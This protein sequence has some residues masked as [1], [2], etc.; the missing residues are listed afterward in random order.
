MNRH[1]SGRNFGSGVQAGLSYQVFG[2]GY[3]GLGKNQY[4]G[5]VNNYLAC[6]MEFS[7]GGGVIHRFIQKR[8]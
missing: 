5:N 8:R 3:W 6:T 1:E 7:F 2:L 4:G